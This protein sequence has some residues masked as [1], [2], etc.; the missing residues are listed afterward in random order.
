M[1]LEAITST[2]PQEMVAL[3]VVKETTVGGSQV[4]AL[5]SHCMRPVMGGSLR[6]PL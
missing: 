3:L 5:Y 2:M 6:S 4:H 1:A